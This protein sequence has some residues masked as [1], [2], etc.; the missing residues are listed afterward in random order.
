MPESEKTLRDLGKSLGVEGQASGASGLALS[1]LCALSGQ[2]C[3]RVVGC[4]AEL[5]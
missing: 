1:D 4:Q 3:W 2:G 5:L